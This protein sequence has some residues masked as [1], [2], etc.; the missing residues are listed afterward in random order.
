MSVLAVAV[1]LAALPAAGPALESS[2]AA[3]RWEG[4][5]A[6][7][8]REVPVA[9]DLAPAAE[10]RGWIGSAVFS[11][12]GLKGAPLSQIA[13]APPRVSFALASPLGENGLN[14]QFE[15]QLEA[16]ERMSGT[17]AHA[18]RTSPLA[19]RRTGEAQ[20][21]LPP[22]STAVA[23]GAVGE[24]QGGYELFGYQR[25][26]TLRLE[27]QAGAAR[28]TFVIE[29]KRHNVLPVDLVRQEGET[30]FVVSTASGIR[31]EGRLSPAGDEIAGVV[32]QGPLEVPLTLR[33]AQGGSPR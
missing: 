16:L 28:A 25:K 8:D 14:A 13:V 7:A 2:G 27:N 23:V 15:L 17:L 19:L 32:L 6:I 18:G 3:G 20:V 24:W 30:L 9:I 31:Y 33:R 29:G 26:V 4:T 12:L 10:G 22:A 11:G 21:D 1:L 5:V